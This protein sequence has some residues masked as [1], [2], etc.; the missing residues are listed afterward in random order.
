MITRDLGVQNAIL[1]YLY[2]HINDETTRPRA[3][4]L[5]EILREDDADIPDEV[6]HTQLKILCRKG[7]VE[8]TPVLDDQDRVLYFAP[9]ITGA[10]C[11]AAEAVLLRRLHDKDRCEN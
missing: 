5:L 10:G 7:L 6:F 1:V 4:K 9:E 8:I 3:S 2:T 11:G